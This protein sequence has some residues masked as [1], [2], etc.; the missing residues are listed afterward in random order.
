MPGM[1]MSTL[2]PT[3]EALRQ[4]VNLIILNGLSPNPNYTPSE[5][6]QVFVTY[7][8][9]K[10]LGIVG[11]R[12]PEGP[13]G[14]PGASGVPEAPN[15]ANIYGRHALGWQ[16]IAQQLA[17]L[18]VPSVL[19][20]TNANYEMKGLNL[21]IQLST[22]TKWL[23]SVSGSITNTQPGSETDLQVFYGTGTSPGNGAPVTGTNIGSQV[24]FISGGGGSTSPF[25][26]TFYIVGTTPGMTYWFDVAM[27]VPTGGTGAVTDLDFMIQGVP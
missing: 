8:A 9:I 13:Q 25:N 11:P 7:A 5:T 3:V 21:G 18:G 23:V 16:S 6:A 17:G 2:Q 22:S 15:D 27:R 26:K 4:T 10:D 19:T 20:T 12:G 14:P 1:N 24:R